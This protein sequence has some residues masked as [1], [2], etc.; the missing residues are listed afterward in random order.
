M[1]LIKWKRKSYNHEFTIAVSDLNII[2]EGI[3]NFRYCLS[4][5]VMLRKVHTSCSRRKFLHEQPVTSEF[6]SNNNITRPPTS[7]PYSAMRNMR[8]Q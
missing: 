3:I 2:Y 4:K 5:V 1:V 7:H 6:Q 8:S